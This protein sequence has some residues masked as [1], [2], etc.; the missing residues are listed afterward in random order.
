MKII[1]IF[2]FDVR[3][4]YARLQHRI[5]QNDADIKFLFNQLLQ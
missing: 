2:W 5:Y 1:T 3:Y 4:Q